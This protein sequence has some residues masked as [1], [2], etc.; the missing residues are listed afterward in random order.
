[1]RC[2]VV[3]AILLE[4]I[5]NVKTLVLAVRTDNDKSESDKGIDE[6][7]EAVHLPTDLQVVTSQRLLDKGHVNFIDNLVLEHLQDLLVEVRGRRCVLEEVIWLLVQHLEPPGWLGFHSA[8]DDL[9][10]LVLALLELQES[11]VQ[12]DEHAEEAVDRR[13]GVH[14]ELDTSIWFVMLKPPCRRELRAV[15]STQPSYLRQPHHGR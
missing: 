8:A 12:V 4:Q 7:V 14:V 10:N 9:A 13:V 6:S 3:D 15:L 5:V 11:L 1:M 2:G